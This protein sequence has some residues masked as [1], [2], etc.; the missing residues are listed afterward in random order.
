LWYGITQKR[1]E[2]TNFTNQTLFGMSHKFNASSLTQYSNAFARQVCNDFFA[3]HQTATGSQ[4]LNFTPI[5][6]VNMFAISSL[7]EKWKS[8]AEAFKSPFFDFDHANVQQALQTFMNVVSQHI[9]VKRENLEPI[10]AESTKN[11]LTLLLNPQQHYTELLRDQPDSLVKVETLKQWQ[12]YT[13]LNKFIAEGLVTRIADRPTIFANRAI[14]WVEE[15][16]QQNP[17][18]IEPTEK[19]VEVFSAVVPLN[20]SEMLVKSS[21]LVTANPPTDT[22]PASFFDAIEEPEVATPTPVPT[23]EAA[24]SG[25]VPASSEA[26]N[27]TNSQEPAESLNDT[28][29]NGADTMADVWQK[30]SIDNIAQNIPLVQKF[31]FVQQLFDSS[32]SAYDAAI[33]ALDQAP[34]Y[35]TALNLIRQ[36]TS[37][38]EWSTSSEAVVELLDVVK[39]R[40]GK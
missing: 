31:M 2:S 12:K 25:H 3:K 19:W 26:T 22:P 33:Q 32:N 23:I 5:P 17:D 1:F 16:V 40:F 30:Q 13:R 15:I 21:R 39:R 20:V 4:I 38:Y 14:D 24:P 27:S 28:L 36:F 18:A 9:S 6:Q 10:L 7:Y 11:T 35:P 34:D 37:Q 29:K 8:D